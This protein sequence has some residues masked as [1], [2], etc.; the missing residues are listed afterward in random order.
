MAPRPTAR[1]QERRAAAARGPRARADA[2]A[3][4]P[5]AMLRRRGFAPRETR[6]ELPL[7][8][9][10]PAALADALAG[11]LAS[12]GFRLFLRGAILA[13]G[14]FGPDDATRYLP[15]E[16]ARAHAEWLVEV[17]LATRRG[18]RYALRHPVANFGGVVPWWLGRELARRLG[19]AVATGV[20]L[21]ARAGGGDLDLVAAAEGRLV[22]VEVKS[23]PPKHL[24]DAEVHAFLA[25]VRAVRPHVAIFALDTALRL[26][27]KVLP[28][29][30]A[31]LPGVA[32]RR[33]V[34]DD[35]ALGEHLYVV[36]A[37]GDLRANVEAALADGFRALGPSLP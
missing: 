25:R 31:A 5:L 7:P 26:A 20:R 29:F 10:A 15:P 8:R 11:R 27:D 4:E 24:T 14:P 34:R 16:H 17:G 32:P 21:G 23:S 19:F 6:P 28:M 3:S 13:A 36:G 37:K 12:Y 2:P 33:L 18:G 22:A 35:W 1:E 30:A 9:D